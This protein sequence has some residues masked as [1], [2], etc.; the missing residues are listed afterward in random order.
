MLKTC[1]FKTHC[2]GDSHNSNTANIIL[3]R[4]MMKLETN[5]LSHQG[6]CRPPVCSVNLPRRVLITIYVNSNNAIFSNPSAIYTK[7][8][9]QTFPPIFGLFAIFDRNLAKIVAPP[10]DECE[11][12]VARLK[13]QSIPKKRC[14]LCRNRPINGN[15][16]R[17]RTMHPSNARRSRL[18]A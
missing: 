12:Y 18:G 9:A 7:W 1:Q 11:K 5:A 10:S 15:A 14:K 16:M 2:N 6:R 4:L 13:V 3:P 17:V 8:C